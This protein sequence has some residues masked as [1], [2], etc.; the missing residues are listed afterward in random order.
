[1]VP[2]YTYTGLAACF[3]AGTISSLLAALIT[4]KIE[5][6]K[7]G[8]RCGGCVCVAGAAAESA[9]G[10][11]E[12]GKNGEEA[13]AKDCD[14]KGAETAASASAVYPEVPASAAPVSKA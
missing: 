8:L 14:V 3:V 2:V 12:K 11:P 1:M 10:K 5:D 7:A 9:D 6:G 13:A 4:V